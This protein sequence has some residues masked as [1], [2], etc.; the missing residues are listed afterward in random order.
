MAE[1]HTRSAYGTARQ[2][3][4]GRRS[5]RRP[6][7]LIF[8]GAVVA[9]VLFVWALAAAFEYVDGLVVAD[10]HRV[11]ETGE[12]VRTRFGG[13]LTTAEIVD[14]LPERLR[15]RPVSWLFWPLQFSLVRD[16][17][18]V[19]GLVGFVSVFTMYAIWWER[20]VAAHIQSRLGPM[21][22]GGWHGWA[23]SLADKIKLLTKEDLVPAGADRILY[24]LAP[25]MAF[26]PVLLAFVALPFGTYWVLRNLDVALLFVLAML[27]IEVIA[28][29][30]A[31]W[32]SNNKWSLYGGMREASQMVAYES[33]MG[34]ALLVP[35]MLAGT[36]NLA[37]IGDQQ[38]AGFHMWVVFRN[39]FAAVAFVLYF[40]AALASCK[41][42]PFDL[43]EAES[44]LVAGF[45]T[46]YSGFRWGVFFFA[47]YTS[48]FVVSGLATTLFLGAWYSPLPAGWGE[49]LAGGGVVAR[50]AHGLLFSGP[51]WFIAKCVALVYVQIWLRWTLPRVRI[52]QV[53]YLFVQVLLPLGMVVLLGNTLWVFL[54]PED[55]IV[56]VVAN[57]LLC[58][59]GVIVAAAFLGVA[60]VARARRYR[61]VGSLAVDHLPGA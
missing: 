34:L 8:F 14:Y 23:Q 9:V 29:I 36:L 43:P 42:A 20:K 48:M 37:A 59:A 19:T 56:A 52:D 46:E 26:T 27:G 32:A 38:Q 1:S 41:R 10:S 40:V 57:T 30:V 61:L 60:V 4:G 22:V 6:A 47:E 49:A 55:G 21:R 31:G 53:L 44:E 3:G 5:S 58:T 45:M 28:V 7:A 24:R 25:Y 13:P 2:A 33:P 12:I 18:A 16:A 50:A 35:I 15:F 51:L 54:V 11:A 39:P 17:I